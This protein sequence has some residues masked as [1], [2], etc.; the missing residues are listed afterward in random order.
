MRSPRRRVVITGMG[1]ITPLGNTVEE[2]YRSAIAGKS[3]VAGITRFDART[4]PTR[5]AAEVRDFA[6]E[7]YLPDP[8]KYRHCGLNTLFA[9]AAACV[10]LDDSGLSPGSN[11]D[12]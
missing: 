9:L 4:F 12:P 2:L 1:A 7:R 5:F 11:V 3:G 8:A 10:A 6:L